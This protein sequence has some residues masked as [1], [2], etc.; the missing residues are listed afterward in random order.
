[1]KSRKREF[2]MP[3]LRALGTFV[4]LMLLL[5]LAAHAADWPTRPIHLIVPYPPG[6]STDVAARLVGDA[7]T[8][9][10]GQ[11]VVVE[12]KSGAGGI[13]GNQA[14]AQAAPDGYTILVTSDFI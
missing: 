11:Q 8:R 3:V 5:P 2:R 9:A 12:N 1:P 14:A 7:L 13:I 6:G 4:A 10:L